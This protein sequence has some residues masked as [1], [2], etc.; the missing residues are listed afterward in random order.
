MLVARMSGNE[1]ADDPKVLPRVFLPSWAPA[2]TK[3]RGT[4]ALLFRPP[5]VISKSI[6]QPALWNYINNMM[7]STLPYLELVANLYATI[8]IS[9][10]ILPFINPAMTLSFFELPY[11]QSSSKSPTTADGPPDAKKTMDAVLIVYGVR[12][13]FMGAAIYAAA[14]CGT[15]QALGWIVVAAG[16]VA[17]TD[18]A[19]CKFMVGKGQMNHWS[20]APVLVV[21]GG[22]ML[23]AFD[24]VPLETVIAKF[25]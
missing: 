17:F 16:C 8:F 21:L 25:S 1:D 10:G 20:Y 15:R 4:A 14:L 9:F 5:H 11:P 7:L 19:V 13:I 24:W 6:L 22:V 18:G 2:K 3:V 23:G 12:D